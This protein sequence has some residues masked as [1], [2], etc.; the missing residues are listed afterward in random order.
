MLTN[1][2][3]LLIVLIIVEWG[4]IQAANKS[5]FY[6][7]LLCAEEDLEKDPSIQTMTEIGEHICRMEKMKYKDL[8]QLREFE[9]KYTAKYKYLLQ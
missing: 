3:L 7:V 5:E 4:I 9:K 8:E 2:I 1:V 6:Y